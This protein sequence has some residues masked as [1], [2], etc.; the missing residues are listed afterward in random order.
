MSVS[1]HVKVEVIDHIRVIR[2]ERPEKKNAL[3]LPMYDAI[4]AALTEANRDDATRV[5]VL[6]GVPG[7]FSA[8]ND[9]ADFSKMAMGGALGEPIV[10]FLNTLARTEK[11]LIAGVDGLAIGVGT[12]MLFHCDYVVASERSLFKTPF[13]DLALVPEAASSLLGPRIM[14]HQKAFELLCM[15]EAFDATAFEKAGVINKVTSSE[16]LE[17]ETLAAASTIAS[18]PAGAMKIARDLMRAA[19]SKEIEARIVEEAQAFATQLRSTEALEAFN[20]FLN[21]K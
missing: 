10:A 6:L 4:A 2:L 5:S 11:P 1:E 20:A 12:T 14:G 9:I 8:G 13:T 19:S 16:A 15:S 3:T 7:A 21:R 18:K 17:A